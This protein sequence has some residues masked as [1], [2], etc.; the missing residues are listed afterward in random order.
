M[1]SDNK[2]V[3]LTA[4]KKQFLEELALKY[5]IVIENKKSNAVTVKKKEVA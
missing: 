1:S 3:R 2:K 4:A 5:Q